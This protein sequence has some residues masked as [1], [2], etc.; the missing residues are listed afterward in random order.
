MVKNYQ[1]RLKTITLKPILKKVYWSYQNN[2]KVEAKDIK[3]KAAADKKLS[4]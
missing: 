4:K 1:N 3:A 2:N